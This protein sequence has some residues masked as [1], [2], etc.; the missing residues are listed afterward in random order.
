MSARA[1]PTAHLSRTRSAAISKHILIA[2][3][4]SEFV[5]EVVEM[6]LVSRPI[7]ASERL[8]DCAIDALEGVGQ[9]GGCHERTSPQS[10]GLL[11]APT[12][13]NTRSAIVFTPIE[14]HPSGS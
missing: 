4:R 12:T 6:G 10:I 11:A 5:H 2:T 9:S 14:E 3:D 8:V 13:E 7:I 1:L